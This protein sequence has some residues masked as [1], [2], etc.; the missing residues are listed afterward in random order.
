M[1]YT[2]P[3]NVILTGH[4]IDSVLADTKALV[5]R[6]FTGGICIVPSG[7]SI[8][9]LTYYVASSE[10]GT[11]IQLYNSSGAVSTTVAA[12]RAYPLPAELA[13]AAYLKVVGDN[14]GTVDLHLISN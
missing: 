8:T 10:D 3:Q 13:G 6:G 4:T 11:Y 7:S 9:S 5:M 12:S 1:A 14:D 2:T